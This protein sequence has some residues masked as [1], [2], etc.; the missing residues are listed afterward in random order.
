MFT[1][2]SGGALREPMS[3]R[4]EA[5]TSRDE[6]T[7]KMNITA[8]EKMKLMIT[9]DRMS[10]LFVKF[11]ASTRR[12]ARCRC[13]GKHPKKQSTAMAKPPRPR[14]MATTAPSAPPPDTPRVYGSASGF[15]R[16]A[17]NTTPHTASD[18]PTMPAVMTLGRRSSQTRVWAIPPGEG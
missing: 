6:A 2:P 3:Q 13:S 9:P 14:R 15:L 8:D 18:A 7:A 10:M 1:E 4:M 16:M 12:R 11:L 5:W 17:W